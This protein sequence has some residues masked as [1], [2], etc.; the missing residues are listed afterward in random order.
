MAEALFTKKE[1]RE[2]VAWARRML[3]NL[4]RPSGASRVLHSAASL[5][6]RRTLGES[7][8]EDLP[9]HP[10]ANDLLEVS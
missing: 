6:S 4:K 9:L 1:K 2:S 5:L 3:K 8:L 10:I 7:R